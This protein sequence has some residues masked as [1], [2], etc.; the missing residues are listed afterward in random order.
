MDWFKFSRDMRIALYQ[1]GHGLPPE[2][3]SS[4][5]VRLELKTCDTLIK[6]Y[7]RFIPESNRE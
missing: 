5:D 4:F 3:E 7:R 6:R 1:C 2:K